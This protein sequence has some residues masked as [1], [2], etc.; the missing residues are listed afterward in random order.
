MP[1]RMYLGTLVTGKTSNDVV[2][3]CSH[4]DHEESTA[5][6]GEA[7]SD[8]LHIGAETNARTCSS[9]SLMRS[10][11]GINEIRKQTWGG[12]GKSDMS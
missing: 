9:T 3:N 5:P 6:V 12:L 8:S 10:S 2:F 4:K 1:S 7:P 11:A